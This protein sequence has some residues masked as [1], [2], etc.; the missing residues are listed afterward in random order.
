[1]IECSRS[2]YLLIIVHLH[3]G[4]KIE[5]SPRIF[6]GGQGPQARSSVYRKIVKVLLRMKF[7]ALKGGTIYMKLSGSG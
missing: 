2:V 6:F 5:V 1:M 4:Q 3:G 7:A